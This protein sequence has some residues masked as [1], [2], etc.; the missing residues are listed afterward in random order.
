M[1]VVIEVLYV[2]KAFLLASANQPH[3]IHSLYRRQH[4][5]SPTAGFRHT[6]PGQDVKMSVF[7]SGGTRCLPLPN[8]HSK[9]FFSSTFL[10]FFSFCFSI[11]KTAAF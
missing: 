5:I 2:H 7:G 3:V 8:T 6:G 1:S 9:I 4:N 11:N 10:V